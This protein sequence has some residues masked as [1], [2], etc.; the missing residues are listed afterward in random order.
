M[1][2]HDKH[3]WNGQTADDLSA[4]GTHA[5][6]FA[7]GEKVIVHSVGAVV[8]TVM[9]GAATIAADLVDEGTRGD[10]NGG[11]IT[12]PTTTAVGKKLVD[13]TSTIFPLTVEA[14]DHIYF[15]VTSAAT[16]GGCVYS[17]TYELIQE[18]IANDDDVTESA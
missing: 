15:Q 5:D 10:A 18:T 9:D 7:P 6:I 1:A 13:T 8:T 2:Y 12:I 14:G 16:S 4:T 17:V 3:V 11:S